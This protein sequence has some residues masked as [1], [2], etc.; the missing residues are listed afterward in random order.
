M[1]PLVTL[2]TDFGTADGYVA[3]LKGELY[4]TV[5]DVVVV[6]LSHDI[7]PQDVELARLVV[8]RSWHR[9][10]QGTVHVVIVDP[11][12]GTTRVPLAVV[13]D[14]RVLLGPD[15]GVLSPALLRPGAEVTA[16]AVPTNAAPTFHGRDVF[17]PHAAAILMG[18]AP[19]GLGLPYPHPEIRRTKEPIRLGDGTIAGEVIAIDRYGNA[20]TNVLGGSSGSAE[21]GGRLIQVVRAYADV[22]PGTPLALTGSSGLL[23]IAIRDG[24]AAHDLELV[25]GATVI[26]RKN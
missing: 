22:A 12:V 16:L 14:G 17:V 9:F 25:R 26:V 20:I 4:A 1:R 24:S 7:P 15:N 18:A 13:S 19:D 5:P 8:A 2:L 21:A 10:P 3:E 6:D 23:E 11:G